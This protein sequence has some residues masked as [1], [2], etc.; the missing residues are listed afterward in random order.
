M[1]HRLG[2]FF[3]RG[4]IFAA[5]FFLV[6][7]EPGL[8]QR[9]IYGRIGPFRGYQ[10]LW[11]F[12]MVEMLRVF[13]PRWNQHVSCG[14]LFSKH[15][16]PSDRPYTKAAFETSLRA[17]QRGALRAAGSW[18]LVLLAIYG[19]LTLGWIE[20]QN[21]HLIVLFFYFADEVC[22]HFWCPFRSFI[23]KNKCCITCRIYNWGHFMMFSPYLFLPSFWTWSLLG[24]SLLLL[25]QWEIMH[26]LYPQ[27]FLA[28]SNANLQCQNCLQAQCHYVK[29]R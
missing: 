11:A 27:R 20:R 6:L 5:A 28:I 3:F 12:L 8:L 29:G 15:F 2:K 9:L 24:L 22:I 14:R 13:L 4:F 17:D 7:F 10:L 16:K 23:V 18:A 26:G 1:I 19:A 25:L 21:L